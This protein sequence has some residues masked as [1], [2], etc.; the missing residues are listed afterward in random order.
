[1][2]I[3]TNLVVANILKFQIRFTDSFKRKVYSKLGGESS[4][5]KEVGEVGFVMSIG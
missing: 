5:A 3:N 2:K 1:M 4:P